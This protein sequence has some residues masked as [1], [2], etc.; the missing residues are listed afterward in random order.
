MKKA[1]ISGDLIVASFPFSLENVRQMKT[2]QER[3]WN[4][5]NKLWELPM[6]LAVCLRL[7][8]YGYTFSAELKKWANW[9]FRLSGIQSVKKLYP[10]QY[11][12][13]LFLQKM[14]GRALIADEMGLGKTIQVLSWLHTTSV[15]PVLVV[16][17]A[18]LKLNWVK[19]A[20]IW[21]PNY[22]CFVISGKKEIT[23]QDADLFVINYD[24][25]GEWEERLLQLRFS[26]L[27]L[28]EVH[29]VKNEKTRRA[30]AVITLSKGI[31]NVI[32]LSGTPIENRPAELYTTLK[33]INPQ[34]FPNK[35]AYLR[36]FCAPKYNG[37]GWDYSGAS[38]LELLHKTLVSRIMLRRKKADVLAD[39]PAKI[40][41]IIPLE[42]TNRKAYEKA[43]YQ[44]AEF[45]KDNIRLQM[46]KEAEA[47]QSTMLGSML[48]LSNLEVYVS[49]K[50]ASTTI[51]AL[52]QIESLKQ[53]AAEG[54]LKSAEEW[55]FNFLEN[56]NKLIVFCTHTKIIQHLEEKF[57]KI[58]VKIDGS[59]PTNMRQKLV[60]MFQT[61]PK[62]KLFLGNIKA[63]GVGITLT[64]AA[65]VCF[66]EYPWT[67]GELVQAID[68]SHRIGQKN[69]VSVHYLAAEDTIDIEIIQLLLDKQK[70]L[71]AVLDAKNVADI[72]ILGELI[73]NLAK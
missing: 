6:D 62:I 26:T 34:I 50:S 49:E 59:T 32:G 1:E 40:H 41:N 4:K 53:L 17:P 42:I 63:S 47:I 38:N 19:E 73:K 55:I 3:N 10:Y 22:T 67:P 48:D 24:I 31:P 72:N 25:L 18:S 56:G 8:S 46:K 44:F 66:L 13:V 36:T 61:N 52:A 35:F 64:S 54:K 68:R 57:S 27:I 15:K 2:L 58:C 12:G 14:N 37:F 23:L 29:Y 69:T 39:L 71:D 7:K 43:R 33:I 16:C 9:Q 45:V 60:E 28:D 5:S 11:E 30:K 51:S 20:H 70:T 65:D 21:A